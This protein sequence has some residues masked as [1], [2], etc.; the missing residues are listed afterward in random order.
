MPAG[1]SPTRGRVRS[2]CPGLLQLNEAQSLG[3]PRPLVVVG[4][5]PRPQVG[6][7][8][9][10][11]LPSSGALFPFGSWLQQPD[12]FRHSRGS[13]SRLL[14]FCNGP[15]LHAGSRLRPRD[16]PPAPLFTRSAGSAG[17]HASGSGWGLRGSQDRLPQATTSAPTPIGPGTAHF[18]RMIAGPSGARGLSVPH[19]W[20][21]GHAPL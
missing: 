11:L 16:E 1:P 8:Y 19:L 17:T 5:F 4:A 7:A 2:P 20:V 9:P 13:P 6:R 10:L 12:P 15:R 18:T 3:A 14:R 21:L